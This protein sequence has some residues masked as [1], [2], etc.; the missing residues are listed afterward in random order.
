MKKLF[1]R[2]QFGSNMLQATYYLIPTIKLIVNKDFLPT[3]GKQRIR[4]VGIHFVFLSFHVWVSIEIKN[5][6]TY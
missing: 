5:S 2:L 4:D 3:F 1:K 6:F